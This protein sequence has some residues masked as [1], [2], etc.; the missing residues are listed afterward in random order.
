MTF[1]NVLALLLEVIVIPGLW[2]CDGLGL[3]H[4]PQAALGASIAVW[5]LIAQFYYRKAKGGD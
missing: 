2:A 1:N 5:T 4:I 3:V